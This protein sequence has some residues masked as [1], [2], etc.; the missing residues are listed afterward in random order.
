VWV[1]AFLMD[2]TEVTQEQFRKLQIPDPS[3]FKDRT[4]PV[5]QVAMGEVIEFCNE[6]SY[7]EGLQEVYTV[8]AETG[9]W[10]CDF[11]ADGYRLPTEAEWEYA[12]RSRSN[13]QRF[14]GDDDGRD[15]KR[16][17]WFTENAAK[18][19]HP[20]GRK[21]PN[22]WGLYDMY[23]NVAEWC[24]D[25]YQ[26]DYYAEGP[27]RNPRGP[28]AAK[29]LV[30]RGGSWNSP[31]EHCR[32]SWRAGESPKLHDICFAKDTIGFRCVRAAPSESPASAPAP[33][34]R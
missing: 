33:G 23:G 12:S 3:H 24:N 1:D 30:L 4:R 10:R 26:E 11:S 7:V 25:Y 34:G 32:S 13:A 22:P 27:Q 17:A 14:Y 16:Y 31:P 28:A 2:R 18:K 20:V 5:E 9:S 15:L 6:R 8:D 19:T 29:L 21:R